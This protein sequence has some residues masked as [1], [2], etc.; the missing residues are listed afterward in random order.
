MV[1]A[2]ISY[3]SP[4]RE[5]AHSLANKLEDQ[6]ISVLFDHKT[7][8]AGQDFQQIIPNQIKNADIVIILLSNHSRRSRWVEAE[9][10][11]A[12]ENNNNVIPVLLDDSATE[13]WVWPL[14]SDRNTIKYKSEEDIDHII[15]RILQTKGIIAPPMTK[16]MPQATRSF[17]WVVPILTAILGAVGSAIII[18]LLKT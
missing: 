12:L 7:L 3:A 2:F 4:D 1:S 8:V 6:G 15:D 5:V 14:I 13:N 18:W 16:A 11:F 17:T 9:L 10:Q